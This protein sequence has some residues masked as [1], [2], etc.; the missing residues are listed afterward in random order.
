[1]EESIARMI[2]ELKLRGLSRQTIRS[3]TNIVSCFLRS[4]KNPRSFLLSKSEGS[5]STMRC[6]YFALKF[7]YE[8]VLKEDF[9][10]NI[11][12][13]KKTGKLPVVLSK[14]EVHQLITSADN[15]K[16]KLLT[17][18]LYYA[19]LRISEL[20]HLCW[21]DLDFH[22][23]V[24]HLKKAKGSKD[25]MVFFHAELK[26]MLKIYG[27]KSNGLV[28]Q[29]NLNKVYNQRSVELIIRNLSKKARIV[30]RVTPQTLRHCFATHLLEA[31]ADIRS[32]QT[33]LGHKNLSTTQIY[34]HI[35]NKDIKKL[36]DLL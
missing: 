32:I 29:S 27:I 10:E 18:F 6:T 21:E 26:N 15:L 17:M 19:G 9:K 1:M 33:L 35:A 2:D 31:G 16:H 22:R 13:A 24:I 23:D 36:A 12:L 28:F 30:K 3:Y 14:E 11:S 34:T 4:N 5:R 7:Y 8:N 20:I 25:R